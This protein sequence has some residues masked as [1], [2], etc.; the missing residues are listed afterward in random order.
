MMREVREVECVECKGRKEATKIVKMY[1]DKGYEII[2]FSAIKDGNAI[3]YIYN[4]ELVYLASSEEQ[5]LHI[6]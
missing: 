5:S 6:R 4:F 3:K 1:R 2:A